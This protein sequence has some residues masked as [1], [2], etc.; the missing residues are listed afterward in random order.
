M[1]RLL[2]LTRA[3]VEFEIIQ[4]PGLASKLPVPV[5]T[6]L[7]QCLESHRYALKL[8]T[9]DPDILYMTAQVIEEIAQTTIANTISNELNEEVVRSWLQ[10]SLELLDRCFTA[11]QTLLEDQKRMTEQFKQQEMS[12]SVNDNSLEEE[13]MSEQS[14]TTIT[15]QLPVKVEDL[16]DTLTTTISVLTI[17]VSVQ[18]SESIQ[19][20]AGMV[21]AALKN[22]ESLIVVLHQDKQSTVVNETR[23]LQ[24]RFTLA[25]TDAEF[26]SGIT[27]ISE[28]MCRLDAFDNL[29][30]T[31]LEVSIGYAHALTD[32]ISAVMSEHSNKNTIESFPLELEQIKS[33]FSKIQSLHE[34]AIQQLSSPK[35]AAS[36]GQALTIGLSLGP[37]HTPETFQRLGVIWESQANSYLLEKRVYDFI[38]HPYHRSTEL[39]VSSFERAKA[40]YVNSGDEI[41]ASKMNISAA[42]VKAMNSPKDQ[43]AAVVTL[44]KDHGRKVIQHMIDEELLTDWPL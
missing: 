30:Q 42:V 21:E 5:E 39:V 37:V 29:D 19:T 25:L 3:R 10:E 24:L 12:D 15:I 4:Q 9:E 1:I 8:N 13:S 44:Y 18:P 16:I 26:V 33:I 36:S 38:N 28:Y 34:Q 27:S 20:T 22:L 6:F 40:Y 2:M 32:F 35:V 7:S 43:K 23:L 11:Q 14:S 41:S 17:L 31:D